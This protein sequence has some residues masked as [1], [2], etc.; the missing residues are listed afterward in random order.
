MRSQFQT[1]ESESRDLFDLS[2]EVAIVT[3]GAGGMGSHIALAFA[4]F[5]ADVV[6]VDIVLEGTEELVRKIS[7]LGRRVL[8][9]KVDV[10]NPQE[11]ENLI[12]SVMDELNRIDILLHTV[13]G[14]FRKPALETTPGEWNKV[15]EKNLTSTFL[16]NRAVGKVMVKQR[17][18]KIINI[19]S[20]SS[21]FP[22]P[23]RCAYATS[24]AGVNQLTRALAIEWAEYNVNVN[25]IVP[26]L[27][28][29]T[30]NADFF[31]DL[32]VQEKMVS[33]IPLGRLGVPQD[34]V[35]A[36]IFLASKASDWVTGQAL[37]VEGGRLIT[38]F[39]PE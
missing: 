1:R 30:K 27:T 10:T 16:C 3:G 21:F 39:Y 24:K 13:G 26:G 34:L 14:T 19:S 28:K 33:K 36:S 18:G 7:S 6:I 32:Q 2:G 9:R 5:G 11:I 23:G 20:C 15:V 29:H 22:Y 31:G 38:D 37:V 8:V 4:S 12:D 17:K 35:G 25:T